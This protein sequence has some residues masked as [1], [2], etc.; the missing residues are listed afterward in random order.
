[1]KVLEPWKG[2]RTEEASG[3]SLGD[4]LRERFKVMKGNGPDRRF[5]STVLERMREER[6]WGVGRRRR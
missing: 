5:E 6:F 3:L 4:V 2:I 1:M